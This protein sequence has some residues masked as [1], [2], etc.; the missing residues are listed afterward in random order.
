MTSVR[1]FPQPLPYYV[2]YA[3]YRDGKDL[4][5]LRDEIETLK[6]QGHTRFKAKIGGLA[7]DLARLEM[8]AAAPYLR[9]RLSASFSSTARC[10]GDTS[11]AGS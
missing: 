4:A 8:V 5:E 9:S 3:Y 11:K 7:G 2:T 1:R 6:G 10:P